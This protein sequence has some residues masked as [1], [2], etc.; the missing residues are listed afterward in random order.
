M[1]AVHRILKLEIALNM[2]RFKKQIK[3]GEFEYV[4]AEISTAKVKKATHRSI[5]IQPSGSR[6]ALVLL[7]NEFT[8]TLEHRTLYFNK[9]MCQMYV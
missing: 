2:N 4:S 9:H 7:L 1:A 5:H 8:H 6:V 3:Q